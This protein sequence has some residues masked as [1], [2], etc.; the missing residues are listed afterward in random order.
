LNAVLVKVKALFISALVFLFSST[1]YAQYIDYAR[2]IIDT[3]CSD[4]YHGRGYVNQGDIKA[5]NFI[6]KEFIDLG[7]KSVE[8]KTRQKFGFTVNTFPGKME[9]NIDGVKLIPGQDFLVSPYSSGISGKFE[10]LMLTKEQILNNQSIK[11]LEKINKKN[12]FLIID[13]SQL[14]DKQKSILKENIFAYNDIC[15]GII[16]LNDKKLT[17]GSSGYHST[18]P[19][20]EVNKSVWFVDAKTINIAI[21]N[22]MFDNYEAYNIFAQVPCKNPSDSFIVFTAHYDHLGRMGANTIFPGANDNAGGTAMLLTLAKYYAQHPSAKYNYLF[23]AFAAEEM[24]LLGSTYFVKNPIISLNKIKF[25]INLDLVGTGDEGITVV[26][27]TQN[28]QA[29]NMLLSINQK[30]Q[31]V[32]PIKSRNNAP[33]SDHYPFTQKNVP[34]VFIYTMGGIQAYHD[35]YDRPETL[36]LTKFNELTELITLWIAK[37]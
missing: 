7:L 3:L 37:L 30:E 24:G 13:L 21:D 18:L 34:A 28:Q 19:I 33:N 4:S 1:L 25:L 5:G 12:T 9:V 22:K 31:K 35:I 36:P 6:E 23:I 26:N 32:T 2:K 29:F 11:K 14:D 27:S 15:S 16:L 20:I 17:W 8:N 10:L